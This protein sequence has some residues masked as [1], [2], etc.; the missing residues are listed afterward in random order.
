MLDFY[1]VS[2]EK[3]AFV[4]YELLAY[5][6]KKWLIVVSVDCCNIVQVLVGGSLSLAVDSIKGYVSCFILY[7]NVLIWS[8]E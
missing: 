5:L 7:C 2:F 6:V 3:S 8:C 4:C 1:V